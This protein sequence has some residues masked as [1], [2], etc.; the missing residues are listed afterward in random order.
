MLPILYFFERR[1][2]STNLFVVTDSN[3]VRF[4]TPKRTMFHHGKIE[5]DSTT[6]MIS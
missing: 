1:E 4:G 3:P 5:N 6:R 2:Y